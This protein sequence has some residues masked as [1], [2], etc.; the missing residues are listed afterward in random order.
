MIL[1]EMILQLIVTVESLLDIPRGTNETDYLV[2]NHFNTA[3]GL[4]FAITSL[5]ETD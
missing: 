2:L 5:G 1:V 3:Q 4:R